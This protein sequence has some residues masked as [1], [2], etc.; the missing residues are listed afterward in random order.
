MPKSS[1]K[2]LFKMDFFHGTLC[3]C[4]LS[5]EICNIKMTSSKLIIK[6][7]TQNVIYKVKFFVDFMS[8]KFFAF[9][10]FLHIP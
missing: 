1:S 2:V 9:G 7:T 6:N 5:I 3:Y 8:F 4:V 10:F